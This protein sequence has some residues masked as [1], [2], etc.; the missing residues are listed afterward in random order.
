M[1]LGLCADIV[2]DRTLKH[3]EKSMDCGKTVIGM[4]LGSPSNL[5]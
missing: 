4:N 3:G 2:I 1:S 5:V